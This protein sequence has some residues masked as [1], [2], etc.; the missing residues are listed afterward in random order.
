MKTIYK[1][2]ITLIVFSATTVSCNYLDIV[3][4]ETPQESDAF[5]NTKA[6]ERFLYTCYSYIPRG[7]NTYN[8]MDFLTGDEVV[9]PFEHEPFAHFPKGNYTAANPQ[10]SY[11]NSLFS[12]IRSCY[13][14]KENVDKVPNIEKAIAEDYKAQADFL[15]G[16]YHFLLV[17]NYGPTIII[18]GVEDLNQPIE[19]FKGRTPY[20]ECVDFA[21]SML[22]KAAQKLP[23]T[24]EGDELGLATKVIAKSVKA[25]LLLTAASPLFNGNS[26]FYSDLSNKDGKKL[27]PLE[28][29]AEKWTKAADAAKE[30]IEL[31]H[32]AGIELYKAQEGALS[33]I[34]EPADMVQRGL[35]LT[36]ID[37]D[38]TREIIWGDSRQ[39]GYYDLQ[40]KSAPYA[41]NRK[42]GYNGVAPTLTM[43]ERFYTKNGLPI[44]K[45]P[46]FDYNK[47]YELGEFSKEDFNGEGKSIK[48]NIDREPRF[49]SWI[50]FQNGYY[51]IAGEQRGTKS[52]YNKK[53]RR[54]H[55]NGKLVMKMMIGEPQGRGSSAE[56]MRKNNYSPTGYLNKKGV[57]PLKTTDQYRVHYIWPVIRLGELYLTYAEACIEDNRLDEAKNYLNRVRNRAGIPTVEQSWAKVPG[58][59]LNKETLRDI[60]RQERM[61]EM[62]LEGQNFWD[63]RRWK[64]A[65]KHFDQQPKGMNTEASTIE[66]WSVVTPVDV[67]RKFTSPRNYLMP[68]PQ[69][70]IN[71]N[72]NLVQNPGY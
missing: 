53:Y 12:G 49:Y 42:P 24:R 31:A 50:T 46:D 29:N 30:A 1:I 22:D 52:I 5:I 10:L 54:G 3:P 11:W 15:I 71:K 40:S 48:L 43:V 44:D 34:G 47:R 26:E 20:D 67:E 33:N 27:M 60:V 62:Y 37:K 63:L 69:G 70:E 28:F 18:D 68:I 58:A 72:V 38:N 59:A 13:I 45:D 57:H 9:T 51:E 6:A 65:D 19:N 64:I 14:L 25:K 17:Q 56:T 23:N 36:F 41:F 4:D 39:E 21:S 55:K 7:N 35:R 16:Y 66:E 8:S 61:I 32:S 2:F